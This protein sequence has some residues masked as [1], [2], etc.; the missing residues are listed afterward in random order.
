MGFPVPLSQWVGPGGPLRDFAGDI[1]GSAAARS[2][3]YLADGFDPVSLIDS[4]T[5]YGRSLWGLL[6][7]ELWHTTFH[8]RAGEWRAL[9][10]EPTPLTQSR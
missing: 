7:L 3:P 9:R 6:S 4:D 1:L 8:D 2:R 5:A 10:Q